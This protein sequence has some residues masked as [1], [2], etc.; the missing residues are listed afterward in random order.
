MLYFLPDTQA[1][2]RFLSPEQKIRAVERVKVNQSVIKSNEFRW[3]HFFE[4][5][6]DIKI[7]LIFLFLVCVTICNSSITAFSQIVLVGLGFNVSG[8]FWN[9]NTS[10]SRIFEA[11]RLT[12][13]LKVK[14]ANLFTI[15]TGGL[16]GLFGIT[17]SWLCTKYRNIRAPVS[18]VLCSIR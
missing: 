13:L 7:W 16:H 5:M 14:Q 9:E 15:A 18:I 17:A 1:N 10:G 4:A 3:D 12:L 6:L 8:S 2:A 11:L